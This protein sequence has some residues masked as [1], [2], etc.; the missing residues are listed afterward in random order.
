MLNEILIKNQINIKNFQNY[1]TLKNESRLKNNSKTI[2]V[3]K[4]EEKKMKNIWKEARLSDKILVGLLVAV[5]IGWSATAIHANVTNGNAIVDSVEEPQIEE[6]Q[7]ADM[8]TAVQAREIAVGLVGGGAVSEVSL[9][10]A[11]EAMVFDVIVYNDGEEFQV[12]LDATDG[13]LIRLES[14]RATPFEEIDL[15]ENLT[16]E[17]AIEIA[18]EHLATIGITNATLVYSYSDVENGTAVWSI[19]FRYSGRDLEFYVVKATGDFLKYPATVNN[20]SNTSSDVISVPTPTPASTSTPASPEKNSSSSSNSNN[21]SSN[22]SSSSSLSSNRPA[23]PAIS[24]ERAIEIAN[25]HL[26]SNGHTTATLLGA[27]MDFEYGRWVWEVEFRY[28]R[29]EIEFYICVNDGSI[30]KFEV[31]ID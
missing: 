8:M 25:E 21:S 5:I 10:T 19:E 20:N 27:K 30:V 12:V 7:A 29:G 3:V 1:I 18:R 17:E 24:R 26:A 31:D 28:G 16:S 22:N 4:A 14:L 11:E 9:N 15:S 23:N 6:V 13:T 2:G